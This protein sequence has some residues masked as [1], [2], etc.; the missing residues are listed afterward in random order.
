MA[1]KNVVFIGASMFGLRCLRA[2]RT[3]E[4]ITVTGVVTAPQT[5]SISY[6]KSGVKNVLHADFADLCENH[7]IP[8]AEIKDGMKDEAL[9][10]KVSSWKPDFF[11][12][13]GW[14]HMLPKTWLDLVPA[15]GLHASLL[16]D[17]SGGAPLV[18]AI[19]NG[20]TET[21][22]SFFKFAAGV[23]NGPIVGQ[24]R[25]PIYY[26]DTIATLYARIEDLGIDLVNHYIPDLVGGSAKL[27]TQD[28]SKRRIMPQRSP[29]DGLIDW[30]WDA[31]QIY[32]FVR[33][34]TS[35]YPGAFFIFEGEKV[36]LWA[37]EPWEGKFGLR[38]GAVCKDERSLI[39]GCGNS[40]AVKVLS[41]CVND[42]TFNSPD[43]PALFGNV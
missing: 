39:V 4:D 27:C 11:I 43:F 15:Y 37:V 10:Q 40:G 22:I 12:V 1:V 36:I 9:L 8:Y 28:E 13:C 35:P 32:N 30:S 41:L 25:T 16:P 19:I 42:K 26:E 6:K 20:E 24:A 23:D 2:L 3:L 14:Y 34:Q 33:A 31:K 29:E 38:P 21:G 18:W 7:Q 5:F 17:Y